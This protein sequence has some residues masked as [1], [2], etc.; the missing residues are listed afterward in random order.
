MAATNGPMQQ[1]PQTDVWPVTA[2]PMACLRMPMEPNA[3]SF[4]A[5][6]RVHPDGMPRAP[7]RR[8]GGIPANPSEARV[9]KS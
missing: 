2:T 8:D 6:N 9:M 3:R 7:C 4:R 5:T 1:E